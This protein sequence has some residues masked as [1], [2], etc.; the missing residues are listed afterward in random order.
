[1]AQTAQNR[2]QQLQHPAAGNAG[3]GCDLHGIGK[4][5]RNAADEGQRKH[6]PPGD[7]P[8]RRV[9]FLFD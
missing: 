2:L 7:Q 8:R 5:E 1:M 6:H 4:D 9:L 3:N